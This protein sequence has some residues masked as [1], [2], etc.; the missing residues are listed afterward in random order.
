MFFPLMSAGAFAAPAN[1]SKPAPAAGEISAKLD[2]IT[3]NNEEILRQLD[4]MKK[5][6]YIIKIRAS[7]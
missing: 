6:L 7:R 3:K 1:T 5:E 2:K 4:E